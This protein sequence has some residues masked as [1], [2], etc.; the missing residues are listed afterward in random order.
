MRVAVVAALLLVS[1][2]AAAY[3]PFDQTD[4]DTAELHAIELEI[5]AM[6]LTETSG[7]R[8]RYAP[9]GVFNY[10][11]AAGW[12]LMVDYDDVGDPDALSL[13]DV[14]VKHVLRAG[15]L[16]GGRGPSVALETG[17]LLPGA[18]TDEL[19]WDADLIVSQR[20]DPVTIHLNA[21]LEWTRDRAVS[22][23][24]GAII[25]GPLTWRVR[26]VAEGYVSTER[27]AVDS[28]GLVGV[29]WRWR[30]DVVFDAAIR[31]VRDDGA[32]SGQLR[33]GLTWAF[34]V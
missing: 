31:V 23:T 29:I 8:P 10:G 28:E 5:G 33:L 16:Q 30:D 3:R 11:F 21:Q 17:P 26:P 19:G 13:T 24:I 15:S 4:A 22:P 9:S 14:E 20:F 34:G 2:A 1:R 7:G 27:G 25:E 18:L 12:E 32:T 6:N